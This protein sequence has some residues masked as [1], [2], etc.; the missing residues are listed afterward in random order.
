MGTGIA[1]SSDTATAA[2]ANAAIGW[3]E[4]SLAPAVQRRIADCVL[5]HIA[6]VCAGAGSAQARYP[7]WLDYCEFSGE[8]ATAVGGVNLPSALAAYRNGQAANALDYD[9]TLVGHPGAAIIAAVLATAEASGASLERVAAGICAGYDVH[10]VLTAA[11]WPTRARSALVRGIGVW[12][13]VAAAVAVAIVWDLSEGEIRSV[14]DV[15]AVHAVPPYV[16]KWYERPV[17]SV[18]NNL[19][20][21]ALAAIWSVELV[22]EGACGVSNALDGPQ[23]FFRIAGSD[24]WTWPPRLDS[25]TPAVMKVGFKRFP[26]C[27]HIQ[28]YLRTAEELLL[29]VGSADRASIRVHCVVPRSALRFLDYRPVTSADVAFSLPCTSALVVLG[30]PKGASWCDPRTYDS[31]AVRTVVSGSSYTEGQG[32]RLQVDS[33]EGR[34]LHARVPVADYWN[35]AARGLSSHEVMAKYEALVTPY[36]AR[37]VATR[38]AVQLRSGQGTEGLRAVVQV[39][40]DRPVRERVS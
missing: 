32:R 13:S 27:W 2:L 35:P 39:L 38:A 6:C 33:D 36:V 1:V 34:T 20:W 17:P 19:G 15:A 9:D 29:Q 4:R 16:A 37:E 5:D 18:K 22:R 28:E 24:R 23:G 30:E 10:Y 26:A 31:V 25:G 40:H 11:G 12:E 21:A 3:G 8:C 14:I 7:S